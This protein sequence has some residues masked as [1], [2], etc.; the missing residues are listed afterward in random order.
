MVQKYQSMFPKI[1]T[2]T[3]EELV[4]LW[5]QI[6]K[7]QD[8]R[9]DS[10]N[11]DSE[12][13]DHSKKYNA[14]QEETSPLLLIDVR[15]KAERAVSMLQGALSMDDLETTK[16]MNKYVHQFDGV[17]RGGIPTIVTY[18]TIGYR[19]G[20]EAQRLV[21]ELTSTF[22]I[23]IGVSVQIKNLDGILAY[24]FVE[25]A[26]PLLRPCRKGSSDSF[27]TR[28]IH[29]YGKAWAEAVDPSFETVQFDS[30]PKMA[31]H[32]L[33]TGLCSA[34]RMVQHTITKT[35]HKAKQTTTT[36][37]AKTCVE[38]VAKLTGTSIVIDKGSNGSSHSS[39]SG[40]VAAKRISATGYTSNVATPDPSE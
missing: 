24:S 38:P 27:M 6:D 29:S 4:A 2:M 5:K 13:D 32:L 30:K 14:L 40:R 7:M 26:P 8:E 25:D 20:R 34:L 17:P 16:W 19:S 12:D 18:C 21:D 28:R 23:E 36:V 35:T 37:V 39:S 22:G 10:L 3:S 9:D 31:K 1:P 33:Q 11:S 15:T